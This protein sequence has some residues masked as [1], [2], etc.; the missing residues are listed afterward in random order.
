[1]AA[2]TDLLLHDMGDRLDDGLRE[3]EA[4]GREWRTAPLV[5]IGHALANGS[6]LLHDGRARSV[7]DAIGWH[8]GEAESARTR[9]DA[10]GATDRAILLS[11]VSGR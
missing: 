7:A 8:G 5:G 1:M 2:F 4:R 6:G 3:G 10:L 9:F 11:F